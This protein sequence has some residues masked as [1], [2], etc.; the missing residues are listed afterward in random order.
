M[1]TYEKSPAFIADWGRLTPAQRRRFKAAVK[2]FVEDLKA[3]RPPRAGLGIEKFEGIE[4]VFEFHWAP[5]GRALFTYG[6]SPHPGDAHVIW[7]SI[8]SHAIYERK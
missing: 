4:G 2:K 7:L 1:P 5:D 3:G 8:G 6:T